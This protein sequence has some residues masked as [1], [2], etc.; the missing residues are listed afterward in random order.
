M[1]NSGSGSINDQNEMKKKCDTFIRRTM[2]E[3][4][5]ELP[6]LKE[7]QEIIKPMSDPIKSSGHLQ[8]WRLRL[9]SAVRKIVM[10]QL[11]LCSNIAL[12]GSDRRLS[13]KLTL[14]VVLVLLVLLVLLW[15]MP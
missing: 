7:G 8:V 5:A 4:L 15:P 14:V 6:G 12:A 10:P 13:V 11:L 1:D 3:N 2:A 9:S